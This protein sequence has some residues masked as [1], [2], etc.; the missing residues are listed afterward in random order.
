MAPPIGWVAVG[1]SGVAWAW[2]GVLIVWV[3][4]TVGAVL[5]VFPVF[6][7]APAI[8]ICLGLWVLSMVVVPVLAWRRASMRQT[9]ARQWAMG[10]LAALLYAVFSVGIVGLCGWTAGRAVVKTAAMAPSMLPGDQ[11]V[12][13]EGPLVGTPQVGDVI[14]YDPDGMG[15]PDGPR[16]QRRIVAVSGQRVEVS[17]D[18][19]S[20]DGVAVTTGPTESAQRTDRASCTRAA[21]QQRAESLGGALRPVWVG[22]RSQAPLIVPDGHVYVLGDDRV[23]S[24]DSRH[25]GTV[26]ISSI[27]G[28]V[29]GVSW[30]TAHCG[31][32]NWGRFGGRP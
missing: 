27:D 9:P 17:G 29:V 7:H 14:R 1:R 16:W 8:N 25:R 10:A 13:A 12:L 28:R 3:L 19:L 21:A 23:K 24:L 31:A 18:V 22:G 6:L 30:P 2:I 5:G 4:A 11:V 20:V 26:P 15:K 32:F